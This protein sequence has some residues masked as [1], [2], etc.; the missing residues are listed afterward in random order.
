VT[1]DRYLLEAVANRIVEIE[2]GECVSYDG[3]YADYL[4]ARAERHD[5][6]EQLE[7]RR[8]NMLAREAAWAARSPS[9][10]STKQ[11]ARLK[12][13]EDLQAQRH[14]TPPKEMSLSLSTGEKFGG[15]VLDVQNLSKSYGDRTLISRL[16]FSLAPGDRLGVIGEN[17]AGK[18]T[19]L[20]MLLGAEAPDGGD[21]LTASRVTVG[22][23]DQA[24]TGLKDD[25]SVFEAAGGGN[26]HVW[27]NGVAV[28][29]AGF[30][31]HLDQRVDALSGGERARLLLAR[32][33]L[34]GS[35]M[36]FL[37]EPTNDLDLLTLRVLEEALLDF[38]GAAIVVTHDRAFL[39]RVCTSVLAFEGDGRITRYASRLQAE[40][41]LARRRAERETAAAAAA[42]A[43]VAAPVAAPKTDRS[44]KR[45]SYH[46][47]RELEGLPGEIEATE[48]AQAELTARL[49]DPATYR[50]GVDVSALTARLSELESSL[51][52]L[53]ARWESLEARA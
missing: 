34:G 7:E 29:V 26:D 40:A 13:L 3:S 52:S 12:R 10:R 17:G 46:E 8:L 19:L 15:T 27:V 33:L 5:R 14:W 38:D 6:M 11:K 45:L 24:R 49:S 1:H 2:D 43:V 48:A 30:L 51:E 42:E 9:A 22:V 16:S 21:I 28:H 25:D 31:E 53:Y 36:I 23:L 35:S 44:G 41:E 37:D 47:R 32:L 39:D 50:G 20:R 18:S 4:I